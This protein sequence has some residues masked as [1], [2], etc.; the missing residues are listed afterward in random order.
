MCG[1]YW[2]EES[3]VCARVRV[4]PTQR[5]QRCGRRLV[6]GDRHKRGNEEEPMRGKGRKSWGQDFKMKCEGPVKGTVQREKSANTYTTRA[7]HSNGAESLLREKGAKQTANK[8]GPSPL[9][10]IAVLAH[11]PL[12]CVSPYTRQL[13]GRQKSEQFAHRNPLQI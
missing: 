3:E 9:K 12:V 4:C 13:V 10:R 11:A 6:S 8:S 2:V 5:I 7:N 1:P